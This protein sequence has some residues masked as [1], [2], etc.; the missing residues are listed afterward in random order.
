MFTLKEFLINEVKP[1]LGCT[2][3]GA[4]ALAVA[5]ACQELESKEDISLV[6]V[7]VSDSIYKNGMDVGIPGAN[8]ARGNAL[9]AAMA[10]QCGKPEYGLEVLKDCKP[11]DI[12]EAQKLLKQNLVQIVCDTTRHGVYVEV[13]VKNSKDEV[14]CTLENDHSNITKVVKNSVVIFEKAKFSTEKV[15]EKSIQ[16]MTSELPYV[17]LIKLANDMDDEDIEY[18]MRGAKMNKEI[19]EYGLQQDSLSGLSLGKTMM[20][21]IN[22]YN[23]SDDLGYLIKSFC[24]A[25]SDARMAGAQMPVMSSAGSG[26]H[27]ITAILPIVLA[28]D[29]L[30]KNQKEIA[31]ALIISHLST[32]FVKSKIGRLSPVCGC[33]VA[34]GAGATAGLTMLLDG[35]VAEAV[36]AIQTLL[37]NTA[38]MIC[39]GAKESCSLK[40]GTAASEAY[41]A[42]LMSLEGIGVE[43]PQGVVEDTIEKTTDNI[44]RINKEGMGR[45]DQVLIDILEI[46]NKTA[47]MTH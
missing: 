15:A 13:T 41:L 10:V 26:N 4:V 11:E 16:E 44:G 39:D 6:K 29:K 33:A 1:A 8:G 20:T 12:E 35:T 24:Y 46:R 37:A 36:R 5:R 18:V 34:A 47:S 43:V 28:G 14:I 45:M 2:E 25:A 27:G 3:P 23:V 32:S 31:R 42:A 30:G 22:K 17:E 38:G 19:A 40:V 9:A 7:V 21:I